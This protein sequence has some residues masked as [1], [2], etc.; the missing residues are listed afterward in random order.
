MDSNPPIEKQIIDP[1]IQT[2]LKNEFSDNL[3]RCIEN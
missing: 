3:I 2:D 1:N